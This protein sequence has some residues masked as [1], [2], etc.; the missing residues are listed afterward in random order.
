[1]TA[2]AKIF[3]KSEM[4]KS[5]MKYVSPS[6]LVSF[7]LITFDEYGVSGHPNHSD[8]CHGVR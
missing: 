5:M 2:V 1:M 7:Q 3:D 8:L 4:S 6:I